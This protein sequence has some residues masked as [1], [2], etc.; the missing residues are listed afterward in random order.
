MPGARG[1]GAREGG[2][3]RVYETASHTSLLRA[4]A[5]HAIGALAG[6]PA[7]RRLWHAPPTAGRR[8]GAPLVPELSALSV[9]LDGA[10]LLIAESYAELLPNIALP[11]LYAAL[12]NE[13][14]R[15]L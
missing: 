14:V 6:S 15:A 2:R 9:V 4:R 1:G 5:Q 7:A 11:P 12:L 10:V 3:A 8:G 13:A